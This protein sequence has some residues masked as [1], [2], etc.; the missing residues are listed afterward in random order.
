MP[1][2][3][4]AISEFLGKLTR[5]GNDAGFFIEMRGRGSVLISGAT[6][7]AKL[8]DTEIVICVVDGEQIQF[9]GIGLCCASFGC[10]CV[11]ISG[12]IKEIRFEKAF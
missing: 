8:T 4:K 1:V 2:K 3:G 9:C 11:E 12:R 10:R 7:I 5:V 6:K